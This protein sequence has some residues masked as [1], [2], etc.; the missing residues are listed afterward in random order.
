VHRDWHTFAWTGHGAVMTYE[1]RF[2]FPLMHVFRR[3]FC[4]GTLNQLLLAM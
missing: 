4:I 3:Y 1:T 2:Y